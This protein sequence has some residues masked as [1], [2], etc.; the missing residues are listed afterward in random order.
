MAWIKLKI[1]NKMLI[2]GLWILKI[3]GGLNDDTLVLR[4]NLFKW[5]D[6]KKPI[7]H[8]KEMQ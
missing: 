4:P 3:L 5:M 1:S 6:T 2:E 7:T 8:T